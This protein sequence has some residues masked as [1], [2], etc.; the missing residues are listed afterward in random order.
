MD[1]SRPG[2]PVLHRLL[3]FAQTH[4]HWAGDAVQLSHSLLFLF[5]LP[6]VFPSIK[7]FSNELALCIR[8]P[9]YWSYDINYVE[10]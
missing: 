1:C 3:E 6:S 4:V 2:F 8:W 9:K 7:V 5:L 10:S